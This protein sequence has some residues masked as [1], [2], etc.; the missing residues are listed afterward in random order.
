M[1][2]TNSIN[3]CNHAVYYEYFGFR[4]FLKTCCS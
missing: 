4:F 1:T 3:L 2:I